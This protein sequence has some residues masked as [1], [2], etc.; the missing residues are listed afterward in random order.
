MRIKYSLVYLKLNEP[1]EEELKV[2]K[3]IK[4][5]EFLACND[6]VVQIISSAENVKAIKMATPDW[7]MS[8]QKEVLYMA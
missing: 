1:N 8:R 3:S 5:V 2:I 7:Y 4:G 6:G